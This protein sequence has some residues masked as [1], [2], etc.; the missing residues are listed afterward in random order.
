LNTIILSDLHIGS[1]YFIS[2]PLKGFLENLPPQADLV[3]NGDSVDR[4][5]FKI[6]PQHRSMLDLLAKESYRRKVIWIW[7]NHDWKYLPSDPG[8]IEFMKSF[9]IGRRLYVSHGHKFDLILLIL[10]PLTNI[11]RIIYDRRAEL[12]NNRVHVALAAKRFEWL[13]SVLR[14]HVALGAVNFARKNGYEAVACGHTHYVEDVVMNG[15][16]YIN[17]GAWTEPPITYISVDQE[18]IELKTIYK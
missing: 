17:T 15:I 3:L 9:N 1:R 14:K 5:R 6:L 8:K 11:I 18:K 10:R 4:R 7:G 12:G 13:Y 2:E 16:R